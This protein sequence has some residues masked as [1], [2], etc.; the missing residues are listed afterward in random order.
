MS[1]SPVVDPKGFQGYALPVSE[2]PVA[3]LKGVPGDTFCDVHNKT[4]QRSIRGGG[5][6]LHNTG[7][8]PK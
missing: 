1:E 3:D 8:S 5:L 4:P 7:P 6:W 2:S